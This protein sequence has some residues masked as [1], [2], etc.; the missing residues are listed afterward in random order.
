MK[1]QNKK[2]SRKRKGKR[3]TTQ[4]KNK[5]KRKNKSILKVADSASYKH[6]QTLKDHGTVSE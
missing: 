6:A 3:K 1:R 4:K 5:K 2:K